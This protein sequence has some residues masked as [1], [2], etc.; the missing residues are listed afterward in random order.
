MVRYQRCVSYAS[1]GEKGSFKCACAPTPQ[2]RLEIEALL[3]LLHAT[4]VRSTSGLCM[5][6]SADY[7]WS[8][9]AAGQEIGWLGFDPLL[10]AYQDVRCLLFSHT[11]RE[12]E[13]GVS[14]STLMQTR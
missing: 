1:S 14:G 2:L 3:S 8:S 13:D 7:C 4:K 10:A 12:R 5:Q 9:D 6:P 11:L